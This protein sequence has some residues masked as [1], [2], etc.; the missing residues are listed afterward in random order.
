MANDNSM[1]FC[2]LLLF[3]LDDFLSK[4]KYEEIR[5]SVGKLIGSRL[6][7]SR[8]TPHNARLDYVCVAAN[9]NGETRKTVNVPWPSRGNNYGI[10]STYANL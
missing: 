4:P 2:D 8:V 6:V 10:E 9:V 1:S 5:N 7:L 3:I